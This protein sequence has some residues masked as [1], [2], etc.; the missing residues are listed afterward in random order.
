MQN[1]AGAIEC[2]VTVKD[3]AQK[4]HEQGRQ[5]KAVD[6]CGGERGVTVTLFQ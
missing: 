1:D 4:K 6:G 2:T 5:L 3:K